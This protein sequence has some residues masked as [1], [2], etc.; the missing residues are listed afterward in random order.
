MR[1][2][3]SVLKRASEEVNNSSYGYV[4]ATL[5]GVGLK[6]IYYV[7]LTI[8]G[9]GIGIILFNKNP[10]I[11]VYLAISSFIFGFITAFVA[12]RS[13]R[14]AFPFGS[15]YCILE[16]M[17]IGVISLFM[18][19][20]APGIVIT[21]IVSTLAIVLSCGVLF[22]TGLVKVNNKFRR[23]LML[24]SISFVITALILSLLSIFGVVTFGNYYLVIGVGFITLILACLFLIND[25]SYAYEL[26]KN[27]GPKE[28]EWMVA[29]GIAYTVIWLYYEVLRLLYYIFGRSN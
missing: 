13:A 9:A 5:A 27:N 17:F 2:V 20:Y 11:F 29:F 23:F 3:N 6:T 28:L 25:F 26:V 16:G 15:I 1:N 10:D 24:F 18:E 4:Q 8:I 22:V 19:A 21:A 14:L 12:M 7:V